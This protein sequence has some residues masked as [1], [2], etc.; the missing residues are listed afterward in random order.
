MTGSHGRC[1]EVFLKYFKNMS[2]RNQGSYTFLHTHQ[3][4]VRVPLLLYSNPWDGQSFLFCSFNSWIMVSHYGF[5][6][7]LPSFNR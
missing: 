1:Y 6:L 2:N 4:C 7:F 5:E 3:P